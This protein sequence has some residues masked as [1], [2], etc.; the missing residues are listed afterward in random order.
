MY[1]KLSNFIG[2]VKQNATNYLLGL[3]LLITCGI[4]VEEGI[5]ISQNNQ[6]IS[7]NERLIRQYKD[8]TK[9]DTIE[10]KIIAPIPAIMPAAA[11][12]EIK[13]ETQA[14]KEQAVVR[15]HLNTLEAK[16]ENII[17][18][19]KTKAHPEF[20]TDICAVVREIKS[21]KEANIKG[22]LSCMA[23]S[24]PKSYVM[25]AAAEYAAEYA[26]KHNTIPTFNITIDK[27]WNPVLKKSGTYNLR[28]LVF[29]MITYENGS[30]NGNLYANMLMRRFMVKYI[31]DVLKKYNIKDWIVEIIPVNGKTYLNKTTANRQVDFYERLYNHEFPLSSQMEEILK[32]QTVTQRTKYLM[33]NGTEVG[34]KTGLNMG[35]AGVGGI[36]YFENNPYAFCIIAT[37]KKIEKMNESG[38][39]MKVEYGYKAWTSYSCNRIRDVGK[40]IGDYYQ[41]Q[42]KPESH[43]NNIKKSRK[44]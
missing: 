18:S 31:N 32:Q 19:F 12:I 15:P 38:N 22:D 41:N 30:S 6:I 11:K 27:V 44:R 26:K 33:K 34:V 37:N 29:D 5:V 1:G 36:V 10:N 17:K 28:N 14:E 42:K 7:Q 4:A 16:L 24:L 20:I 3:L 39:R 9:G 35:L 25:L 13:E 43:K 8:E 2:H 23:A 21:G 40:G